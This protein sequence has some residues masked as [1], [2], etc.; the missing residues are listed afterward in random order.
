MGGV[1]V[2]CLIDTGSMVST[3]TESF[4]QKHFE[5]W[6]QER[7]KACSWLQL[8][9]AN[10]LSIPYLG[11]LELDVELCGKLVSLCG[12]LVVKDPPGNASLQAPGVLGMNVIQKCYQELFVQHGLSLFNLPSVTQAPQPVTQAL[13][14]YHQVTTQTSQELSGKAKVREQHLQRLDVVLARLKQ[15]RLKAKL[16]KCTFFQ[17]E[18]RYLGHII[19]ANGV[20]TDPS[21][22]EAVA[23]WQPPQTVSELRSF[24][25][26]ASYYRRFVEGFATL[27]APLHRL[28]AEL[29]G[30]K[31]RRVQRSPQLSPEHWKEELKDCFETLKTK[32]TN[33]PV[34]AYADF[35]LPFILEVDASY[36]GLGA[37][38]S[39]EQNGKVRPIAYA[40][41]GLKPT[42]RNMANYSS[43]KL[44]FLALKWAMT[45]KFR[46]YLLGHRCIVY[47]DN[48]PLSHLAT[49]KLGATEQRW[50]AQLASFDFEIKYRSGR[51]NRNADALSR[52]HPPGPLDMTAMLPGTPLPEPLRQVLKVNKTV[53]TQATVTVLPERTPDDIHNLQQA[54]HS[55]SP[56]EPRLPIDFLL[57][58]V[59]DP[60]SGGVHEW[61]QEHQARLQIAF[62]GA[63]ECM[64]TAAER[65]KTAHDQHLRG[66]PLKEGLLPSPP[67]QP[68]GHGPRL[69]PLLN[70]YTIDLTWI[71][72]CQVH[73]C[74]LF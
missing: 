45:E 68:L 53:V 57:A 63:R 18:V 3:V 14:E 44:E 61:I 33:A 70:N 60:V 36:G 55:G 11:Y 65:R 39:Q 46:E 49:A 6:G 66:E 34:L 5:P 71:P 64:K 37:V 31:S 12:I 15:E 32:L 56:E 22:I 2:P 50:A 42:E 25:G 72:L 7:L 69:K 38:L 17:P 27:A 73:Q 4:F 74:P 59:Q 41:R 19:S 67:F 20:A 26:F 9:A 23:K 48:N 47:T 21:K 8:R 54:G 52:Q 40:S 29:G 13:Q 43:M 30:T 62:D 24:L 16:S 1:K 28:I 58:R 35:S 10:G 51:S